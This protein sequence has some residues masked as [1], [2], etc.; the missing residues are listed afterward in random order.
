MKKVHAVLAAAIAMGFSACKSDSDKVNPDDLTDGNSTYVL[1]L[2]ADGSASESTDYILQTKDLM[3]G[4]LS[5][6]GQGIEQKSYRMYEQVGKTLLSIT[7]QGTNVVP[8]YT[9]NQAGLLTKKNGE[10]S[11]LRLHARNPIN[12]SL[13]VGMYV[14]RDGTAEATVYEIN[15]NQMKVTRE[16]K[17]NVFQAAGNGKEWAY[18][19]DARVIGNKLWAPFFQIKN[20]SF[21]TAY[22]DTAYV[23]VYSYPGLK[24]EKVL[25]DARTGA[26][27][28][29]AGNDALSLT[30]NGDMYT[31]SPTAI[32]SGSAPTTKPSAV[33]RIKNGTTEFD[34]DYFFN[35]E[36]VTGGYKIA[37]MKYVGNGKALAQIYSFKDHTAADKW[38]TRDVRLAVLD[39][40]AKTVAYVTD[41]PLH[42][43]GMKY[44]SIVE[45]GNVYIQ[46]KNNDGVFIYKIDIAAAKGTKGAQVQGKSVMGFFK[47]SK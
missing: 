17:V 40:N 9:L 2:T 3:T 32:A 5:P 38:T 13:M 19:N 36:E 25:K 11:I 41:V 16:A 26:I 31:Y 12:D 27:G 43:G 20:S 14:P 42:T 4:V 8:G 34:K 15:A 23:A 6:V 7:Y 22:A 44:S 39:L 21:E 28:V 10:F 47:M 18:F 29:Y 46:I 24:L 37:S 35:I 1:A 33:M 30:E 45:N